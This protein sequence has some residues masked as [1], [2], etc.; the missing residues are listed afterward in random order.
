M[1]EDISI[2]IRRAKR[3]RTSEFECTNSFLEIIPP[4][5]FDL[6]W[7]VS[8]NLS[9]NGISAVDSKIKN[10]VNL[11]E[12]DLSENQITTIPGEFQELKSLAFLN[13]SDNPLIG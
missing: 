5:L 12:L 4:T 7:L 3:S 6:T 10:L 13:L 8:L 1:Q 9:K 11:R 2:I